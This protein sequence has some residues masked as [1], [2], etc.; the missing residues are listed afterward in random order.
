M[1]TAGRL[2]FFQKINKRTCPFIREVRV[3]Q[4]NETW[5]MWSVLTC[6]FFYDFL[7][8]LASTPQENKDGKEQYSYIRGFGFDEDGKKDTNYRK[9]CKYHS[10][11]A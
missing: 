2:E 3:Y 4:T 10:L 7:A 1:I 5:Q 6:N 11:S 9:F 8:N